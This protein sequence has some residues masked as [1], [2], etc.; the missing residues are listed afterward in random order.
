M[1]S[2]M[3]AEADTLHTI[4]EVGISITGFAG[5]V[6][7]V[8]RR[9]HASVLEIHGPLSVLILA[10]LSVVFFSFVPEWLAAAGAS[11]AAI[12]QISNGLYGLYRL[13]YISII[14]RASFHP[15]A[16]TRLRTTLFLGLIVGATGVLAGV[17]AFAP[18]HYFIYLTALLFGLYV[19]LM[20]FARLLRGPELDATAE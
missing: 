12:W 9:S 18:H 10:S 14:I 3:L 5:I 16:Q 4:A 13:G 2:E 6:A 20:N 7:A 8:D 19:A 17:G 1:V 15:G 11:S